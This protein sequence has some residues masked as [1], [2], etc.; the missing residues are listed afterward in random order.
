[1]GEHS[2]FFLLLL[3]VVGVVQIVDGAFEPSLPSDVWNAPSLIR[4]MNVYNSPRGVYIRWQVDGVERIA[5]IEGMQHQRIMHGYE[6]SK[7]ILLYAE[8]GHYYAVK[9]GEIMA[10]K[11]RG[12]PGLSDLQSINNQTCEAIFRV[13][14][15]QYYRTKANSEA[16]W[17]KVYDKRPTDCITCMFYIGTKEIFYKLLA[18]DLNAHE[19]TE[20]N[21]ID[22]AKI[23]ILIYFDNLFKN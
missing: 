8:D 6:C 1:M 5:N 20:E 14:K 15:V 17:T 19:I 13:Y 2:K 18:E 12:L 9:R 23:Q 4:T 16:D 7:R 21:D 3:C 22:A 10:T 11:I